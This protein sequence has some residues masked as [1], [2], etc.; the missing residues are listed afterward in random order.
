MY[1]IEYLS[2]LLDNE[3]QFHLLENEINHIVRIYYCQY[4]FIN[5]QR[6]S[7]NLYDFKN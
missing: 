5:M 2:R 4:F 7:M 1:M 3:N 6:K